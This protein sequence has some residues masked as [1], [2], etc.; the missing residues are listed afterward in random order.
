MQAVAKQMLAL[1]DWIL[2]KTN[3]PEFIDIIK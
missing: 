3:K 2:N 1:Y